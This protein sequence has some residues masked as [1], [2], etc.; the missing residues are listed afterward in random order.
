MVREYHHIFWYFIIA[1]FILLYSYCYTLRAVVEKSWCIVFHQVTDMAPCHAVI[2]ASNI[3][4]A[5]QD[6][7]EQK[8]VKFHPRKLFFG[9][10]GKGEYVIWQVH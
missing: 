7:L 4:P 9:I 2:F 1:V 6:H 3:T 5:S 8:Y 10:L